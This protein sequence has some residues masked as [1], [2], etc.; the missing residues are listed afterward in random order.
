MGSEMTPEQSEKLDKIHR[1]F[2]EPVKVNGKSRAEKL[3]EVFFKVD[4][5]TYGSVWLFRLLG[6][7]SFLIILW[8]QIKG[9]FK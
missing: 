8:A 5:G 3:D 2:F 7:V 6:A 9:F 1:Y 4:V